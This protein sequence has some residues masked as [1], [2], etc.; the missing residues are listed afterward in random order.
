MTMT[1][2]ESD[3]VAELSETYR[4]SFRE[5]IHKLRRVQSLETNPNKDGAAVAVALLELEKARIDYYIRRDALV[6]ELLPSV[7]WGVSRERF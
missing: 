1:S 5:F 4:L 2:Y 7:G 6:Q 3:A